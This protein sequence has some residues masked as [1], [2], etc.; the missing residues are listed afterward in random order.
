LNRF[1]IIL[2][3]VIILTDTVFTASNYPL[4]RGTL[5]VVLFV[6][7][8]F[9]N[10]RYF[11]KDFPKLGKLVLTSSIILLA[12][13]QVLFYFKWQN[14]DLEY[15]DWLLNIVLLSLQLWFFIIE[16]RHFGWKFKGISNLIPP[17]FMMIIFFEFFYEEIPNELQLFSIIITILYFLIFILVV[18]RE[19]NASSFYGVLFS[20]LFYI[21]HNLM[22]IEILL[23]KL[24]LIYYVIERFVYTVSLICFYICIILGLKNLSFKELILIKKEP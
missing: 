12:A 3:L 10:S 11:P 21:I 14:K 15:Y 1:A 5:G 2:L 7:F 22:D 8:A 20:I 9:L 23:R 24:P 19:T 18:N 4:V 6:Y 16:K 13:I 17:T